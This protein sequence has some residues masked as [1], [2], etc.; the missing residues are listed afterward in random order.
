MAG[1]G[2]EIR[3]TLAPKNAEMSIRV[4]PKIIQ[5]VQQNAA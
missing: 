1:C 5:S 4:T 3:V 2:G